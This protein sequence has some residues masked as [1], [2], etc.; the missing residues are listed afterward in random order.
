MRNRA[1]FTFV[2]LV[3][4]AVIIAILA[5]IAVPNFLEAQ[6]RGRVAASK[7]NLSVLKMTL[8]TYR[9]EHRTYPLN[10]TP[11]EMS[12]LDLLALTTP[13]PYLTH[14]PV[15]D[16]SFSTTWDA[17]KKR[18]TPIGREFYGYF[19]A[20][21]VNPEGGLAPAEPRMADLSGFVAGLLV[22]YG[23]ANARGYTR[24]SGN[25]PVLNTLI[26]P[27]GVVHLRPYDTTNGSSSDGDLYDRLP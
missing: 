18:W 12:R 2:E 4:V 6:V 1:G 23:P 19:N 13:V 5:A 27:D 15:D 7:A 16:F 22:G 17:E 26:Y 25:K 24:E 11:G 3:V 20:V 8:E 21:Q 14:L 10:A 9:L